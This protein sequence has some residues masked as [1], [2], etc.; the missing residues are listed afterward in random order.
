[1][2]HL[3]HGSQRQVCAFTLGEH[4]IWHRRAIHTGGLPLSGMYTSTT[5]TTVSHGPAEL[6]WADS[7]GN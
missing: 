7:A 2:N 4:L 3:S 6:A 5:H 1:M